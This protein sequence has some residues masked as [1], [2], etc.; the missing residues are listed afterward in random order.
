[1]SSNLTH[2]PI[3][4]IIGRPNVGK[5]SLFNRIIRRNVAIVDDQPGITRDSHHAVFTWNNTPFLLV[6]TGG[7]LL[8]PKN[9]LEVGVVRIAETAIEQSDLIIFMVESDIH[10]EDHDVADLLRKTNKR[11]VL[12]INKIDNPTDSWSGTE[13][14]KFG[15]P[16]IFPL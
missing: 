12:V 15:F 5:S 6:D 7:I 1:M 3:V 13:A 11:T 4:A 10:P 9:E 8:S 14:A 16:C 2:L